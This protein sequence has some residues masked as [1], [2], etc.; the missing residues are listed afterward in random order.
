M[1]IKNVIFN[2]PATIVFW[3][4]NTK[5]VVKAH[6]HDA[7]DPEFGLAMA[8]TKKLANNVHWKRLFLI[9]TTDD[10]GRV[11]KQPIGDEKTIAMLMAR[12]YYKAKTNWYKEFRK[13]IPEIKEEIKPQPKAEPIAEDDATK[14]IKMFNNGLSISQ[15]SREMNMTDYFVKKYIDAATAPKANKAKAARILKQA[16]KPQKKK[17]SYNIRTK[18][19][20]P[21]YLDKETCERVLA[22]TREKYK[23][24]PKALCLSELQKHFDG[25]CKK[26]YIR[27]HYANGYDMYAIAKVIGTNAATVQRLWNDMQKGK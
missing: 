13:W 17:G 27:T 22:E 4:D 25:A 18:I 26:E 2:K 8:I 16:L 3:D 1:K 7:F 11:T 23:D 20:S 9:V 19:D 12:T 21:T 6:K 15:I 24:V 14:I 5:T 10:K